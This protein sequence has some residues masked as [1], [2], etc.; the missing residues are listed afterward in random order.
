MNPDLLDP[1]VSSP[2]SSAGVPP[3]RLSED[4]REILREAAGRSVT[5]GEMEKRLQGRGFALFILIL[6]IPFC[7]PIAIPGLS[8][9]FGIVI[10]LLGLRIAMGRKPELPG[11]ILR[12]EIKYSTL[13]K[14]V[15]FGLKI[16]KKIEMAAVPRM[17]FL[18]RSPAAVNFI[19]IGLASGGLLLLLP[20][21]PVIPLSNTIPAVSVVLLTAGLIERDGLFVLLGYV[22]NLGAW[23]YFVVMFGTLGHFI[24][25]ILEKS[26]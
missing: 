1:D 3:R 19:G 7:S 24:Q 12:K 4:F 20:L 5:L 9:P 16:C 10:M 25:H 8:I 13:E 6:S 17:R 26:P 2:T 22:V 21:P 14:I 18:Q 23:V 15:G 11:F